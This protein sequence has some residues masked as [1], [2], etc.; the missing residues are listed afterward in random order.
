[1]IKKKAFPLFLT[2]ILL[3][4]GLWMLIFAQQT[5]GQAIGA[6]GFVLDNVTGEGLPFTN[7]YF[8]H[9]TIG[10]TTDT[11]GRFKLKTFNPEDTLVFS[12]VGYQTVKLGMKPG[13]VFHVVVRMKEDNHTL[14]EVVIKPGE[15]PAFSI[16]R[17]IIHH[18][19]ENDPNRLNRFSTETYTN[20]SARFTNIKLSDIKS[21]LLKQLQKYLPQQK[22]SSNLGFIP[23]FYS[24]KITKS[25][26]D[27]NKHLSQTHV[28][29]FKEN[30][31]GLLKGLQISRYSNS[32]S[33]V[34]NFYD[35]YVDLFGHN[36][37]S[38]IGGLGRQ[39]Y[40]Y[41][42]ADSILQNGRMIY[43][44]KYVPKNDKDLAFKGEF[45]VVKDLWAIQVIE[46]SLPRV[47]NVN[48]LNKFD[49][50][51][52]YQIIDDSISFFKSNNIR[53]TFNYNKLPNNHRS[54]LEVN[55]STV[56]RNVKTGQAAQMIVPA[57]AGKIASRKKL[58]PV[59]DTIFTSYINS[60][61]NTSGKQIRQSIDSLNNIGWVRFFNKTTD[62]FVT[63]YYNVGKYEIGPFL[64]LVQYNR[65][66][67]M[68]L[69]FG[70]RTGALFNPNYSVA[71]MAGYGFKDKQWKYNT[72]F[73]W[74][75]KTQNRTILRLNISKDLQ[76]FGVYGHI[77]LIKENTGS[78][79]E[80]S[81]ISAILKRTQNERRAMF[82][83]TG[84]YIEHEWGKGFLTGL[85]LE[86][87]KIQDNR[88]VPFIQSGVNIG[89]IRNQAATLKLRFSWHEKIMDRFLRRYYLGTHYPIINILGTVGRFEAGNQTGNYY[90][91]HM[92]LK[93]R[94]LMGIPMLRYIVE[95]GA[96]FGKVPFPLLEIHRGNESYGLSRFR[97]NLLNNATIASDRYF[98][99][100]GEIFMNGVI[101]NRIPLLRH[102]NVKSVFSAKYLY[103]NLSNKHTQVVSFPWDMNL[104]GHQYL[105]LGVGITS[106][107]KFLRVDYIWRVLPKSFLPMPK[108]GIRLK[109]DIDL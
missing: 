57:S 86:N 91:I 3:L 71:A 51:Y 100:M 87:D 81:F 4:V 90:K 93:Q 79:G 78:L 43:T 103:S 47:A 101:M 39:F 26:F 12:Q 84:A 97:F 33:T 24:E 5:L 38:P 35:N 30:G 85:K 45:T 52:H 8:L 68:R 44:I 102:L 106:I 42:L 15:N 58:M 14:D 13:T 22:D 46:A 92:T 27:H 34:M 40:K 56:Y 67:G 48:F 36:F 104:P 41:Y 69:S 9:S 37:V 10:T 108:A 19:K 83:Q 64:N 55:K 20:I 29:A 6:E 95:T 89:Q 73:T 7:I 82:Y 105:E 17:Q 72:N 53:A 60:A 16:I 77:H 31:L 80:D 32:L 28:V 25:F 18:R 66:E 21:N 74:K 49:V 107:F 62:M 88:Y 94:F 63:E 65:V 70:G 96:L 61:Q 98:S 11:T 99:F 109:I 50:S 54:M 1:M 2:R 76:L 75:F 23:L 59:S